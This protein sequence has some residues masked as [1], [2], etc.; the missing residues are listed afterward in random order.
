MR[1]TCASITVIAP[2][3]VKSLYST[4]NFPSSEVMATSRSICPPPTKP[5]EGALVNWW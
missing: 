4:R 1:Y 3:L 2:L 5:A